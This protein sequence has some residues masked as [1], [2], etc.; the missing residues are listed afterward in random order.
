MLT[1]LQYSH[2]FYLASRAAAYVFT[3]I[4]GICIGYISYGCP[5]QTCSMHLDTKLWDDWPLIVKH[6][7]SPAHKLVN[8]K[9]LLKWLSDARL[10]RVSAD[11]SPASESN[12]GDN[13]D[14]STTVK[15]KKEKAQ[16]GKRGPYKKTRE[17]AAAGE[18]SAAEEAVTS[19][20][21]QEKGSGAGGRAEG[22]YNYTPVFS[23]SCSLHMRS[24]CVFILLYMSTFQTLIRF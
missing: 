8:D 4:L 7:Q 23:R 1:I 9:V 3:Y 22:V 15:P 19:D 14:E 5:L 17:R 21:P 12:E 16:R 6:L 2:S 13:E 18:R 24:C 10:A 11:P 20:K